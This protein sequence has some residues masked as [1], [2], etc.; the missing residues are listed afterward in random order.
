M[1]MSKVNGNLASD[2]NENHIEMEK[3]KNALLFFLFCLLFRVI[4]LLGGG[5][6]LKYLPKVSFYV[7][8]SCY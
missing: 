6:H 7:H 8:L 1:S 5:L 4:F 2:S 3:K